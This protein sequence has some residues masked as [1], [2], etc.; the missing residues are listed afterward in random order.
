[1]SEKSTARAL[2]NR[3]IE[4]RLRNYPNELISSFGWDTGDETEAAEEVLKEEVVDGER[5]KDLS[6]RLADSLRQIRGY[7]T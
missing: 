1:M 7:Q 4:D 6:K 5:R 3:E 2:R